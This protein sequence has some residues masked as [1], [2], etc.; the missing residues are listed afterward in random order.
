M[1]PKI[2]KRRTARALLYGVIYYYHYYCCCILHV[3]AYIGH[4]QVYP[5]TEKF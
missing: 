5:N 2:N 3:S 4:H 1:K